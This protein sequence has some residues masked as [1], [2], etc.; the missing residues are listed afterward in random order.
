MPSFLDALHSGRILL[1]DGAMGTEL[2]RAGIGEG[3]CYELWN[4]TQPDR[5]RAVHQ[6]YVFS[7]AE[8]LLTNTFQANPPSLAQFK[9]GDRLEIIWQ[10][11][12]EQAR[13]AAGPARFVLADVGPFDPSSFARAMLDCTQ[14]AD[15]VL[16]ETCSNFTLAEW[17]IQ[18]GGATRDRPILLSFAFEHSP[19]SGELQTHLGLAPEACAMRA[20]DLGAAALGVNCGRDLSLDDICDILRRYGAVCTLPLFAR[21][22][23][24]T[25][26]R[27]YGRWVYPLTPRIMADRL[28]DLLAAGARM[29]GGC[30]GTTPEH[31]ALVRQALRPATDGSLPQTHV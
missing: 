26:R 29:V 31:I 2:Q 17:F 23:A 20:Q 1:M 4:L 28:P 15:A 21:P 11:A 8:I 6:A 3:E 30:C 10:A 22:N 16:L 27:E 13:A 7:G 24:G 25:P 9:L 14:A 12:L 5:V 19:V 18:A